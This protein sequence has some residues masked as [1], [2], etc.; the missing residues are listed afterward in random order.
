MS[1]R[2]YRARS[3]TPRRAPAQSRR[4]SEA[5][6]KGKLRI[7]AACRLCRDLELIVAAAPDSSAWAENVVPVCSLRQSIYNGAG[8][9]NHSTHLWLIRQRSVGNRAPEVDIKTFAREYL[10]GLEGSVREQ[11]LKNLLAHIPPNLA[12]AEA[13]ATSENLHRL[14]EAIRE[15]QPRRIDPLRRQF[16]L[17]IDRILR[18]GERSFYVCGQFHNCGATIGRLTGVS[19]EGYRIELAR[20]CHVYPPHH[21]EGSPTTLQVNGNGE[22]ARFCAL[23]ELPFAS[24]LSVGWV[25]EWADANGTAVEATAPAVIED[26]PMVRASLLKELESGSDADETLLAQQLGSALAQLQSRRRAAAPPVRT[27]TVGRLPDDADVSLIVALD[28]RIDLFEQQL[29]QFAFDADLARVELVYVLES[30]SFAAELLDRARQLHDVY[31]LPM[32]FV[33]PGESITAAQ[34]VNHAAEVAHGRLL[35]LTRNA[36]LPTEPGWLSRMVRFYESKPAVGAVGAKLLYPAGDSVSAAGVQIVKFPSEGTWRVQPR[37]RGLH[38]RFVAANVTGQVAAVGEGCLLVSAQSLRDVRL[39]N[40]AYLGR[41]FVHVDFCLRLRAAGRE[42]WYLSDV[43][44]LH[45]D[46][47]AG[48][49]AVGRFDGWLF[50]QLWHDQ[51]DALAATP[52]EFQPP[53]TSFIPCLSSKS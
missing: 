37:C 30:P 34:A 21:A 31:G 14:R 9:K 17:N 51:I 28:E 49:P 27:Q 48:T 46:N 7:R 41:E 20:T 18:I 23:F 53:D 50:N 35:L 11:L 8:S 39:L 19:P 40:D 6:A 12:P 15:R 25:F 16:G 10:A 29:V 4:P 22:T 26:Q 1:N 42:N 44:L 45:F 3:K 5:D 47:A 2:V 43:E 24:P 13:I 52:G 32:R 38:R 33:V 36:V